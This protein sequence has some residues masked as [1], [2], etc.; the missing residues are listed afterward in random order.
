MQGLRIDPAARSWSGLRS[1]A[2][3]MSGRKRLG[4]QARFL[5]RQRAWPVFRPVQIGADTFDE[6]VRWD[7]QFRRVANGGPHL[8]GHDR[9]LPK[10]RA[11]D[12]SGRTSSVRSA[13]V[14]IN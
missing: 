7:L 6:E 12:L 4:D 14:D 3:S 8:A 2:G 11:T 1:A 5:K 9:K 10:N 13:C